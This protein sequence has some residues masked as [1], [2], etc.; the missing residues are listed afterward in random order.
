[1]NP[2]TTMEALYSVRGVRRVT[3]LRGAN[4]IGSCCPGEETDIPDQLRR[5]QLERL[6]AIGSTFTTGDI[7]SIATFIGKEVHQLVLL[8]GYTFHIVLHDAMILTK[9]LTRLC[10]SAFEGSWN[11]NGSA[12]GPGKQWNSE[13]A[14]EHAMNAAIKLVEKIEVIPASVLSDENL[15]TTETRDDT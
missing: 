11:A 8:Q 7:Y 14:K 2:I 1:M 3:L 6:M 9:T 15:F 4:I 10:D 5:E 12:N 13:I